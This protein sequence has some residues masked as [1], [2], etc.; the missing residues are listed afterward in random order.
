MTY[1]TQIVSSSNDDGI[2]IQT[3]VWDPTQAIVN[4]D[5]G[6]PRWAGIRYQGVAVPKGALITS[7]TMTLKSWFTGGGGGT[8]WGKFYGDAA[9]NSAAFSTAARS[10]L[11]PRTAAFCTVLSAGSDD[12]LLAHDVTAII[13]EIV[14]RSGWAIG[15]ALSLVGDGIGNGF[16]IFKDVDT[17]SY[18]SPLVISF[19]SPAGGG[20]TGRGGSIQSGAALI[21]DASRGTLL[22]NLLIPRSREDAGPR[23]WANWL[24]DRTIYRGFGGK[25]KT[26]LGVRS[27]AQMYLG[28]RKLF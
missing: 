6:S 22:T 25:A 2:T 16:A 7:A 15:N 26:Y 24:L 13:Q 28:A 20:S 23:C 17:W 9:D 4:G 3:H 10:E 18:T 1:A 14:N 5:N 27:E 21:D 12:V 8:T 11:R 19:V